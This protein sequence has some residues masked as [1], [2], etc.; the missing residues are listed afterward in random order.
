MENKKENWKIWDKDREYGERFYN[1]IKGDLPEM[2]SSKAL[3][4]FLKNEI[5]EGDNILDVGCG[6]G[7][8]LKSLLAEFKIEFN[9]T[10]VDATKY[11]IELATKA[12]SDLNNTNFVTGDIFDLPFEDNSFDIVY[13]CNVFLHLPSIK[14]P[15]QELTRV[16]K[17]L[18]VIRSLFSDRSFRIQDVHKASNSSETEEFNSIGE[19]T[20][21][22]Y[23]N[24][25]STD[26]FKSIA[27]N[28]GIKNEVN[29]SN[30]NDYDAAMI[31]KE[32]ET[33]TSE[34]QSHIMGGKQVNGCILQPWQFAQIK[35]N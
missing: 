7:H 13:C 2:E 9:Y 15:L 21:F 19:P 28:L 11:Y 24:I 29:F 34:D 35:L 17:K 18:V 16:A 26:Y 30:D 32:F 8:Y 14:K 22:H 20:E 1:R 25:Y 6:A 33:F 4:K 27:R 12:W 5:V 31:S 23:Y 10:G 3:A